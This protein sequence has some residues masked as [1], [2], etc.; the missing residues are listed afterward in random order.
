[1]KNGQGIL[2]NKHMIYEGKFENDKKHGEGIIFDKGEYTELNP[3]SEDK[4]QDF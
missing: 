3:E 4:K 1:L 2:V